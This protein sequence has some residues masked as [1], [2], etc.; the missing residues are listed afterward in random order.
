MAQ[1]DPS[2]SS[3]KGKSKAVDAENGASGAQSDKDGK[4]L[5]NGKKDDEKL[6]RECEPFPGRARLGC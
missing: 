4:P 2:S 1:D 5:V 6:N 3:D